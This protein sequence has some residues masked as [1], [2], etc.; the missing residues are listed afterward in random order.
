[1]QYTAYGQ[2]EDRVSLQNIEPGG[3]K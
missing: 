3:V 1:M 2:V